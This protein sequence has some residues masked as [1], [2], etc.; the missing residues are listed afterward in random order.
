MKSLI[1]L[2]ID[3]KPKSPALSGNCAVE[4][5]LRSVVSLSRFHPHLAS[6]AYEQK[7]PLSVHWPYLDRSL[8]IHWPLMFPRWKK[9]G[10]SEPDFPGFYHPWTHYFPHCF[11]S[12]RIYKFMCKGCSHCSIRST[13]SNKMIF[14]S[15]TNVPSVWGIFCWNPKTFK[16]PRRS[17]NQ[18]FFTDL[19]FLYFSIRCICKFHGTYFL[20]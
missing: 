8:L 3:S 18:A 11:Y 5:T 9:A 1:Q 14:C 16:F 13:F 6:I 2:M 20:E 15:C 4:P 12:L 7:I 10:Q 17:E 19:N